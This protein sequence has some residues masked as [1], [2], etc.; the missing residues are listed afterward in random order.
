MG[1]SRVADFLIYAIGVQCTMAA[2]ASKIETVTTKPDGRQRM[3]EDLHSL[4]E[5]A[6][7]RGVTGDGKIEFQLHQGGIASLKMGIIEVKHV[8]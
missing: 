8:R 7:K 4:L 6:R 3:L 1:C 2:L 5:D